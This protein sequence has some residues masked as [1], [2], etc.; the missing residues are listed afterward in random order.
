VTT[1]AMLPTT[2]RAWLAAPLLAALAL[3]VPV[4]PGMAREWTQFP[5]LSHGFAIPFVAAYL[6]WARRGRLLAA[7]VDPSLGGLPVVVAGVIGLLVGTFGEEPF[8]ARLSLP[9]TLLG[10]VW[11]LAGPAVTRVVWPGIAYLIFMVPL[12]WATL[13][14][15]MY[16]SRLLDATI[17]A[18]VLAWSGLP[19]YR[20]GVFLHLPTITLEVADECSSIP[21]LAALLALGIAYASLGERPVAARAI[22][23]AA[24]VPFA[25][26][27]NII[28]IIT[29]VAGVHFI[30]P[31]TLN[32][33]YHQSNGTVNFLLTFVLLLLLDAGLTAC[34]RRWTR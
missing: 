25:V 10:L 4:V 32:T 26:A 30:G 29:V 9:I 33:V 2:A 8:L 5:S 21:A 1:L 27:S 20:E 15:L 31:G 17:V 28:R 6:V 7:P 19:I 14:L 23:I 13:K 12:P 11:L 18:D 34:R 24:A 22:L 3:Y 16:R